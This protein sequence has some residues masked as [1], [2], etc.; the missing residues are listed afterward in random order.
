VIAQLK[1]KGSVERGWIG[2]KVQG[3]NQAIA[4]SLGMR[5]AEG[6]LVDEVQDGGPAAQAGVQ[7]G[8]VVTAVNSDAVKNSRDL[9][10]KIGAVPPGTK[11]TLSVRRDGEQKQIALT[12][13]R[14]PGDKQAKADT[15]DESDGTGVPH[16][17]LALAPAD[18]VDGA[19]GKGLVVTG[20][21][22]DGAAAEHGLQTGDV[23]LSVGDKSVSNVQEVRKA[24]ADARRN[25]RSN[26]LRRV[27]SGDSMR[28][29]ALPIGK[30]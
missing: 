8:D 29:I 24:L 9:A 13:K 12:L 5:N 18:Q 15:G 7:P 6:A 19:G 23:I 10:K 11:V 26:V 16:L 30:A 21:D 20:V 3:V 1:D 4:E 2:V 28:F 25:G 17:G 22:S 14:M 27:K